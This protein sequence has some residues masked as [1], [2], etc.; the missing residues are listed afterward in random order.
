[1]MTCDF[2]V[3]YRTQGRPQRLSFRDSCAGPGLWCELTRVEGRVRLTLV[4]AGEA[5]LDRVVCRIRCDFSGDARVWLNGYQSWTDSRELTRRDRM[6]GLLGRPKA[7]VRKYALNGYGD[8][9]FAEYRRSRGF[10]HGFGYGYVREQDRCTL[11]GSLCEQTGFTVLYADLA[12]GIAEA[13]KDCAGRVLRG[14]YRALE[15]VRLEG[16][17]DAVLAS[18]FDL[19]GA[20]R[21]KGGPISGY[22]SWYRHG[23]DISEKRLL[24]DLEGAGGELFQ[25]DDGFEP[26]VGDWL[27]CDRQKFP[28]GLEPVVSAARGRGLRAGLWLAPFACERKSRL[29][30]E[31][32]DWLVRGADG[33]PKLCGC[34]WSGF[35]ALDL[36]NEGVRAYLRAVFL[37]YRQLGFDFFKL[38][39]LYAVCILPRP[40]KTRG[41]IAFDAMR[42]LRECAGDCAILA[43]GAPVLPCVGRAEY[44]RVGCDVS[45]DWNGAP[46]M[47]LLHRER[48]GT[49]PS[50][51]N[52]IYR[53]HLNG[54]VFWNDP[55]V[56]FLRDGTKLTADQKRVLFETGFLFGS[57]HLTSDPVPAAPPPAAQNV[58][59]DCA[60]GVMQIDF[61]QNGAPASLRFRLRDGKLL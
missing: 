22:T 33:Q 52:T 15:L 27:E 34:N 10:F 50:I 36:Y 5:V 24:K 30:Q 25:I 54:R 13:R 51:L 42:F 58:R 21:P 39:F 59:A 43:C 47:R 17:K 2:L 57:V 6:T 1:M 14:P 41:E 12:R 61:T 16:E 28:G 8:Y 56:Y 44:L 11:F 32:P 53:A 60:G 46:V 19:L 23:Q 7:L 9:D 55:D 49:L 18:Y 3:E 38:D 20:P 35:A 29:W 4:P 26:F 48:T 31:H 45:P 40:D 37:Q